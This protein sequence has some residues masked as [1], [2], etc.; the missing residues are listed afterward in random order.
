MDEHDA[1]RAVDAAHEESEAR[2]A[3]DT[4]MGAILRYGM[5]ARGWRGRD[6]SYDGFIVVN[7]CAWRATDPRDMLRAP[8]PIGPE[9]R[10]VIRRVVGECDTVVCGWGRIP[11]LAYA[12]RWAR[13]TIGP[14]A[15]YLK[16]TKEGYPSHP[17]YLKASLTP[18][19]WTT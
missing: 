18:T 10:A 14:K 6:P 11:R 15:R 13:E 12:G 8:N 9:N 5:M 3:A 2:E 7:I 19:V 16:L 4:I 17:L 1:E